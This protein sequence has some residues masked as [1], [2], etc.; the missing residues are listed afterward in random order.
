MQEDRR[1][2]FGY[3]QG[4]AVRE[5]IEKSLNPGA[6]KEQHTLRDRLPGCLP[7]F[8]GISTK[9]CVEVRYD[10]VLT[11][12]RSNLGVSMFLAVYSVY[13]SFPIP[14]K[15]KLFLIKAT[16]A[17][18]R[19][20]QTRLFTPSVQIRVINWRIPSAAFSFPR[21]CRMALRLYK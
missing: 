11:L 9:N 18:P 21:K 10:T 15:N 4:A 8:P 6:C 16:F 5:E 19:L 1:V 3:E 20:R 2:L 17:L 12:R 7:S 13:K 14:K